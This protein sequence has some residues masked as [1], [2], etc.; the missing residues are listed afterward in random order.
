MT[1]Q[2]ARILNGA[3]IFLALNLIFAALVH[4][5]TI[6]RDP[7]APDPILTGAPPSPCLESADYADRIST[8]GQDVAPADITTAA[9][10]LAGSIVIAHL[11][12]RGR[13]PD[14]DA[15]IDLAALAM[16]TCATP[17]APPAHR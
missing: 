5:G 6:V 9:P 3:I 16:P 7:N 10:P 17:A 15:P 13:A 8:T 4:A 11:D 14:I 12:R 2:T 1:Q